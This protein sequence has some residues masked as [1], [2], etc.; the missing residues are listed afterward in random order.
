V[1]LA[2]CADDGR[3]LRPPAP[4]ATTP[5]LPSTST[6]RGGQVA[7]PAGTASEITL[8][9]SSP[10]FAPGEPIPVV[11]TCDESNVSPPLAWG[12]M[13]A[14]TVELALTVTDPDA[15][16]FVHWVM[17]GIDPSVQAIGEGHVPEGAVQAL[18]GANT[19]GWT[20]PCPPQGA[21]HH[22][23]FTIYALTTATG[24]TDGVPA[25]GAIARISAL[26]TVVAT[27]TGTY[28]RAG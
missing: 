20:G 2:A 26:Q 10:A 27:L 11:H 24:L 4:G 5:P 7:G 9:L 21:P 14:G 19:M 16:G 25:A 15:S 12:G 6:T 8:T 22:Y 18:N 13:P 28:Q 17:A 23:V 3:A 1:V